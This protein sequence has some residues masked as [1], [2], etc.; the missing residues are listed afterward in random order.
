MSAESFTTLLAQIKS[1]KALASVQE[2]VSKRRKELKNEKYQRTLGKWKDEL[3][4]KGCTVTVQ[5]A[6]DHF[7]LG[8]CKLNLP[9]KVEL[10]QDD[11]DFGEIKLW[12]EGLPNEDAQEHWFNKLSTTGGVS[13][14]PTKKDLDSVG[15]VGSWERMSTEQV[16]LATTSVSLY[17]VKQ[18]PQ[19]LQPEKQYESINYRGHIGY[20]LRR[21]QGTK[22]TYRYLE[23]D[24]DDC[25]FLD[26]TYST[27]M[28]EEEFTDF[29]DDHF[30][31]AL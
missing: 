1:L 13:Y 10:V 31:V 20:V 2:E 21:Q 15:K 12:M 9:F 27:C 4:T 8:V 16:A 7:A 28:S 6:L 3:Q 24:D 11:C 29:L 5:N 30:I 17:F 26:S 25:G 22:F 19:Q 23:F 18:S 14:K